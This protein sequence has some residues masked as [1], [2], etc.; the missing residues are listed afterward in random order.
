MSNYDPTLNQPES[1]ETNA[2]NESIDAA[3]APVPVSAPETTIAEEHF[4][5]DESIWQRLRRHQLK[6]ALGSYAVSL[7]IGLTTSAGHIEDKALEAGSWAGGVYLASEIAWFGGIALATSGAGSA[8]GNPFKLKK[9]WDKI[10]E[11]ASDNR[12]IRS[13]LVISG[14][15]GLGIE[16]AIVAGAVAADMPTATWAVLGPDVS[17][18]VGTTIW[19]RKIW[20]D[21]MKA[22]RLKR[23]GLEST[24]PDDSE[25]DTKHHISVRGASPE[26]AERLAEIGKS[27]YRL[28]STDGEESDEEAAEMFRR[29]L[30]NTTSQWAFVCE[31]DGKIEGSGIAFRTNKPW[32]EFVSWEESTADGTLDGRVDPEGKYVYVANLTVNPKAVKLGGESMLTARMIAECIKQGV[33]YGYFVSRMPIFSAWIK[34][35]V[36]LGAID[37]NNMTT[38]HMDGLA[39]QYIGLTKLVDGR[40]VREDYELRMYEEAGFEMGPLVRDAF[41]DPQSLNYGVLFKAPIPPHN[42][43]LKRIKPVRYIMASGLKIASK[44][45]KLLERVL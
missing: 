10:K 1:A 44:N 36:R 33:E 21:R 6:I 4:R 23:A 45:P 17:L 38:E 42:K 9:R 2:C 30:E 35:Q 28:T 27:R 20:L 40:E 32:E 7:A 26:D 5:S 31:V 39:K 13:G 18:G 37:K 22:N 14:I 15:G 16:A 29:R 43:K 3:V 19:M 24:Q 25:T 41:E 34:R 11:E 8:V 12:R